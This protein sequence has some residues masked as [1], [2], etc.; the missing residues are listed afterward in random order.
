[1]GNLF[2][3]FISPVI[4]AV[5]LEEYGS[6]FA[7]NL[8]VCVVTLIPIVAISSYFYRR[9]KQDNR[10]LESTRKNLETLSYAIR[11][12]QYG[13]EHG[14]EQQPEIRIRKKAEEN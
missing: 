4:E 11:R 7:G 13:L 8:I 10:R 12:R 5:L 6:S 14:E 2:V 3:Q 9:Q 1:M